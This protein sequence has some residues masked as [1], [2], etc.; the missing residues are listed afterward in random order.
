MRAGWRNPL[1]SH[2]IRYDCDKPP[3]FGR[4]TTTITADNYA[5]ATTRDLVTH[6]GTVPSSGR[7][8]ADRRSPADREREGPGY[9]LVVL[10]VTQSLSAPIMNPMVCDGVPPRQTLL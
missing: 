10:G 4:R 7:N 2:R 1:G 6:L 3:T 5:N 8:A 9:S